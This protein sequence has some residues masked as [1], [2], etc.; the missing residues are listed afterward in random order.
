M[1]VKAT[2]SKSYNSRQKGGQVL[3]QRKGCEKMRNSLM[4]VEKATLFSGFYH[5]CSQIELLP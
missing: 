4:V 2:I 5:S 3:S 1:H